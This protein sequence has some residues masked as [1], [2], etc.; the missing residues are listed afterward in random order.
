MSS[1]HGLLAVNASVTTSSTA[2][3]Q[4]LYLY[5]CLCPLFSNLSKITLWISILLYFSNFLFH[6]Q[7]I[8]FG[9]WL[10]LVWYTFAYVSGK[11]TASS[12][13]V[14]GFS[15]LN[16]KAVSNSNMSINFCIS[17]R[18]HI[19]EDVGLLF[20]FIAMTAPHLLLYVFKKGCTDECNF[21]S[22]L[23]LYFFVM[24]LSD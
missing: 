7:E 5:K 10:R 16:T 8:F 21:V 13:R 9:T 24:N 12:F 14:D 22:L 3:K 18:C 2:L 11:L 1:R 17:A 15:T 4:L 20:K 19:T 23:G 6:L